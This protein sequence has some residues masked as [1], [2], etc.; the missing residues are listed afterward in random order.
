MVI[1]ATTQV[2]G[3][4]FNKDTAGGDQSLLG[5]GW[6]QSSAGGG[7]RSSSST[8]YLA[9]V[10]RRPN[11]TV[12]I[13]AT[14][15]RLVQTK[16]GKRGTSAFRSV[17]FSPTPGTG[18]TPAGGPVVTV[19]ARK[20]V[21][22]SAGSVGTPQILQLSGIGNTSDLMKLSIQPIIHSPH[23]G[24]HLSDHTFLPNAFSVKGNSTFDHIFRD[25]SLVNAA[26]DQWAT[27]KSGILANSLSNNLGFLRLEDNAA[28]FKTQPDPAA[29]PSSPHWEMIPANMFIS[30]II[31]TPA[32]GSFL[33]VVLALVSP[34]SRKL[35]LN[36]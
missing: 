28:I 23:V 5:I 22:L 1:T 34:T 8:S 10:N 11:L 32:T 13:N 6:L 12:L 20:E 3:F 26:L 30:P 15:R 24:K 33:T 25:P 35:D 21:I 29:G 31:S 19:T 27:E 17:Q 18:K 16:S 14:V 36:F 7:V 2:P 4:P 9:S